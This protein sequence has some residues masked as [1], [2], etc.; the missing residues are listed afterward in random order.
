ML[1]PKVLLVI[2]SLLFSS[3][4]MAD[5]QSRN[6]LQKLL[7]PIVTL[8]AQFQ[9]TVLNDRNKILQR[10]SGNLEFK[11][12]NMFRWEVEKPEANLV[13]TDG[14][15]LWN[16]DADLEQVTV[17]EFKANTEVSPV[18]FLFDDMAKLK[19]DFEIV[20]INQKNIKCFERASVCFRLTPKIENTNFVSVEVGFAAEKIV[21]LRL[22][23]HLGQT[24]EFEFK[25]IKNN[26]KIA[27]TRFTFTPPVGVDVIGE[28]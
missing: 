14:N 18:S 28:L 23:D 13:V 24:S 3:I 21:V 22:L 2:F 19:A 5:T 7:A 9:Q 16:Y 15:K 4:L 27:N 20:K 1:R 26:A 25:S 11:K 17:Q 12:P 8:K 6:E 10:S